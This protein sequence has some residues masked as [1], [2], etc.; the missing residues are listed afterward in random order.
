MD[1]GLTAKASTVI[2]VPVAKVWNALVDPETIR[3]YMFGVNVT[4]DW[5][6]GGLIVW[7]GEW[8]GKTYED[9]GVILR[10]NPGHVFQYS[11]FS[12]R[13]G[14]PDEPEYHHIVTV[15]LTGNDSLTIVS[16]SQDNNPT[17]QERAHSQKN[18]ELMLESMK[19]LLEK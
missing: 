12:P 5:E 4:S 3:Q 10:L 17:E 7:K 6:V 19:N 15:E 8:Q 16:L 18:W 13:S 14:L 2:S 1:R 9:R 11:H